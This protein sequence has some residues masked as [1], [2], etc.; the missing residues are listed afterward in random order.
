[1][2]TKYGVLPDESI[3]NY[4]KRLTARIFKILPLKEEKCET[5]DTYIDSIIYELYGLD[6]VI[7]NNANIVS[8]ISLLEM[9]KIENKHYVYKQKILHC[10]NDLIPSLFKGSGEV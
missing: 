2:F 10:T 8:L 9:L 6:I 1:M 7:S 5:L 3:A 4:Q